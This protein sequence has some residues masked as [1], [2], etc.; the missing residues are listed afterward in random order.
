RLLFCVG[1]LVLV[2]NLYAGAT[3]LARETLR[4][5]AAALAAL[6]LYDLNLAT[7]AYLGASSPEALTSLRGTAMLAVV[8]M[9]ALSV[10]RHDGNLRFRPSRSLTFQSFS[11]LVIGA[12]L[13]L[14]VL[15]AQGLA[16][17][18]GEFA[19]LAQAGFVALAGA[20]ALA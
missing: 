9:L 15:V 8:G 18:G 2:H 3:Q 1:A 4:W 16:Y 19:R 14:M 17:V 5:P 12:Y 10:L 7:V 20:V 11:L 13:L 6:W